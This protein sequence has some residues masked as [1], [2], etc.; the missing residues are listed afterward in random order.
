ME[1]ARFAASNMPAEPFLR[2]AG[3]GKRFG[4]RQVLRDVSFTL[5]RAST[6]G[7]VGASGSGKT[8]LAR[9]LARFES[10]D[11]GEMLLEGRD[12][13]TR[14]RS[15]VQLIP[16]Q[17]AASLN[18]RF[19][20]GEAVGEPLA[21]RGDVQRE[22]RRHRVAA[23]MEAVGLDPAMAAKPAMA[24]SGG[25]RQRLAIARALMV[26]PR[27]LILDES[28][29]S[30]DLSIQAQI[31]NLLIELQESRGLPYI[32]ISHDLAAVARMADEI[33]VMERGT[34]VECAAAADLAAR[35]RHA[36]TRALVEANLAL[37]GLA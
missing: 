28:L 1:T 17:P 12:I 27:L 19:T 23:A 32:L 24:F 3:L 6:L 35:P 5:E 16:Q 2:V 21:I 20:A 15:A 25:E 14:E 18:P 30:L 11:T 10:P 22:E 13:R 33:A 26:A 29:A 36:A 7:I 31:C 34:I 37:G 9:C 4:S 8:T